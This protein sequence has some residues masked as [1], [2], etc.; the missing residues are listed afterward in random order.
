MLISVEMPTQEKKFLQNN[1][2]VALIHAKE[3]E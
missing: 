2:K 3:H 1:L